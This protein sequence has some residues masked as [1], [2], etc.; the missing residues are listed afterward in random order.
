MQLLGNVFTVYTLYDIVLDIV[1]SI[2][3]KTID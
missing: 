1:Y 3:D 2:Y